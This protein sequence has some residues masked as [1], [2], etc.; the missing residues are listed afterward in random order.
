MVTSGETQLSEIVERLIRLEVEM[1]AN[2]QR[3]SE[4]TNLLMEAIR[5]NN[6]Q[7]GESNAQISETNARIDETNRRI[8]T[9]GENLRREFRGDFNKLAL[10]VMVTGA[11]A[12]AAVVA[13]QIFV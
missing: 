3:F 4:I 10:L 5:E 8:D 13:A 12:I 2:N 7:I 9:Q 6:R 11:T 1:V